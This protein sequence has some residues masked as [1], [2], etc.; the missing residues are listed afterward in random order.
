MRDGRDAEAKTDVA[1]AEKAFRRA[2][3]LNDKC[4]RGPD[5]AGRVLERRTRPDQ[6]QKAKEA[7]VEARLR[8]PV[9]ESH[10]A[11]AQMYEA[12]RDKENAEAEYKAALAAAPEDVT[13]I[14]AVAD[15]YLRAE[16]ARRRSP[17]AKARG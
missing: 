4:A 12:V 14:R 5:C 9:K 15:F 7:L 1:E 8:L 6:T 13:I 2:V 17:P 16:H 3:E 10:A 11:F